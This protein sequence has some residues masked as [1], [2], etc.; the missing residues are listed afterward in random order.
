MPDITLNS[1]KSESQISSE[2]DFISSMEK[3]IHI[4]NMD[5]DHISEF[6]QSLEMQARDI[7]KCLQEFPYKQISERLSKQLKTDIDKLIDCLQNDNNLKQHEKIVTNSNP[8][9]LEFN[10]FNQLLKIVL[11]IVSLFAS[12]SLNIDININQNVTNFKE[13]NNNTN[14]NFDQ[15]H[16]VLNFIFD[17]IEE[18]E[19]LKEQNQ[20]LKEITEESTETTLI[21]D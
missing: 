19:A 4:V 15:C 9:K 17:T 6:M 1:N 14:I 7:N 16:E 8:V 10:K 3:L 2:C 20:L 21:S 18:N 13:Q 12:D 5:D 11:I